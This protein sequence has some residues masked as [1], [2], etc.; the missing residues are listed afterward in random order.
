MAEGYKEKLNQPLLTDAGRQIF[1]QV[2]NGDGKLVY[3]RATLS[4]RKPVD[5]TG[6]ALDDEAIRQITSLPDDLK[7]GQL[8][9]TPVQND[10]FDVIADFNNRNQAADIVFSCI[11]WFARVDT[12]KAQGPET[13]IAIGFTKNDQETLAA[14]SPDGL[15]TE[16]ISAELDVTIS[17]AANIDMHVNEIGYV[18]R[19]EL[20]TWQTKIQSDITTE[21]DTQSKALTVT[22]NG[23]A[24]T[25]VDDNHVIN[26]PTYDKTTIDQ[27]VA[28]AGKGAGINTVQGIA[29]N[30]NGEVDLTSVFYLK[31]D[32]DKIVSQQNNTIKSLQTANGNKDTQITSLNNQ[33]TGLNNQVN[34]LVNRVKFLEQNAMLG[35]R[36]TKAQ[37]ADATAW[38]NNNPNYI[39]IVTDN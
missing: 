5:S 34:D 17:D 28:G 20:N 26:L 31:T 35:K 1:L 39:A 6:K 38:E 18:T 9:L 22:L 2:G 16:V 27:M 15:S 23:Q 11:G 29:P 12:D 21:F 3:T 14:G 10:H 33:I 7:E 30:S 19:A 8:Q 37:E 24:P 4:S 13:L 32:V 36:F 25:K